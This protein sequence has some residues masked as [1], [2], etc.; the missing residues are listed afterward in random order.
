[1]PSAKQTKATRGSNSRSVK[2][3]PGKR[4]GVKEDPLKEGIIEVRPGTKGIDLGEKKYA[5]A[6]IRVLDDQHCFKGMCLYS[7]DLP[8]DY[9]IICY[10]RDPGHGLT[11]L[12]TVTPE[13]DLSNDIMT[14]V[15]SDYVGVFDDP[16]HEEPDP[17]EPGPMVRCEGLFDHYSDRF[18]ELLNE[19]K[20]Y[21][22]I[23]DAISK[24]NERDKGLKFTIG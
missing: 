1:M 21:G 12:K 6:Y 7:N 20:M 23:A 14:K 18:K 4:A 11:I 9:D 17:F 5:M 3:I 16:W 13:M 22:G 24:T 15:S 19:Q 2:F 10:F 8:D